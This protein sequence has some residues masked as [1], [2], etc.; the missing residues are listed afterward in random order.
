MIWWLLFWLPGADSGVIVPPTPVP[1]PFMRR[2]GSR[3][4][5]R[6]PATRRNGA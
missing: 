4:D 1:L 5:T 3:D 2:D 6:L